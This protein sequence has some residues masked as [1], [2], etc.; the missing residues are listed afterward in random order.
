MSMAKD[1]NIVIYWNVSKKTAYICIFVF[2]FVNIC[3]ES[4]SLHNEECGMLL[5]TKCQTHGDDA[6]RVTDWHV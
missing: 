3:L 5:N 2:F 4:W 6:L 1:D